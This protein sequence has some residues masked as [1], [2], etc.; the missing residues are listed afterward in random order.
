MGVDDARAL[1]SDRHDLTKAVYAA[2]IGWWAFGAIAPPE[3]LEV[4]TQLVFGAVLLLAMI[5]TGVWEWRWRGNE[6]SEFTP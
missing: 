5:L 2:A 6:T 3:G 4:Y 1:V